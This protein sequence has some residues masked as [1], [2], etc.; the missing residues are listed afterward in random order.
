MEG[1]W[2]GDDEGGGRLGSGSGGKIPALD[3]SA[4]ED[5]QV[6]FFDMDTS[7]VDCLD[8]VWNHIDPEDFLSLG[9]KDGS[10]RKANITEAENADIKHREAAR[11]EW[12]EARKRKK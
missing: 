5:I 9:R 7:F 11:G 1:G 10:G 8:N 3:R 6:G 12:R 2:N 4:D